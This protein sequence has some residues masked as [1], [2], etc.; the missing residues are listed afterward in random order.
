MKP[1]MLLAALGVCIRVCAFSPATGG[2]GCLGLLEGALF[3]SEVAR[4]VS[5]VTFGE[6]V[7]A[8]RHKLIL[9]HVYP[10]R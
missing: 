8:A 7:E 9:L 3:T 1:T 10:L 4:E 6:G 2:G 5:L